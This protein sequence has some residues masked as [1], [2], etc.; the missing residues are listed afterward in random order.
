[1]ACSWSGGLGSEAPE[2]ESVEMRQVGTRRTRYGTRG[3]DFFQE[4]VWLER[5]KL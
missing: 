1:M 2:G 4:S 5:D 3:V